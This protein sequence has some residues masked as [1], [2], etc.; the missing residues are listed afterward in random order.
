MGDTCPRPPHPLHL[1]V[2]HVDGMGV[3]DVAPFP[4]QAGDVLHR[5]GPEPVPAEGLLVG[6][7]RQVGVEPDPELT[8]QLGR[9]P[10]QTA[11]DGERGARG[12]HQPQHRAGVGV[13]V[14]VHDPPRVL[15][16]GRLVLHHRVGGQAPL[17]LPQAHRSPG[18]VE[19]HP[20]RLGAL[21]L[22][23]EPG[24]VGPQVV[25]VEGGGAARQRQLGQAE[26]GG[27]PHVVGG[28]AGPDGIQGGEPV[29]E[30]A[31]LRPGDDPGQGLVEVVVGVD[32]AG[33]GEAAAAVD[34]VGESVE[35][36]TRAGGP[37]AALANC[38]DAA[39]VDDDVAVGVLG[40]G[41]VHRRH[42]AALDHRGHKPPPVRDADSRTASRIFS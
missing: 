3:P 24:P 18:H 27:H 29:E 19:A 28:H 38:G 20:H 32:E 39:V 4:P 6:G 1:V 10:H 8:R 34:A 42:R 5:A 25:V 36:A 14:A 9:V 23:V 33:G 31:V 40:A 13:V 7:L 21:H 30:S 41:A 12:Q 15:E 2:G 17:R 22:I 35:G 16:D 37:E 11:A 26:G